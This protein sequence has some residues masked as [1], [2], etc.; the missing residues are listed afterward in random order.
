VNAKTG[1]YKSTCRGC[2]TNWPP[3]YSHAIFLT[4]SKTATCVCRCRLPNG[5]SP[6]T[7]QTGGH[8]VELA[9]AVV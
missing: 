5:R 7:P 3:G 9:A 8:L 4:K 2:N 1:D 6:V